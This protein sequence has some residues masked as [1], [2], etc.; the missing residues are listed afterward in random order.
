M[1]TYQENEHGEFSIGQATFSVGHPFHEK[2]LAEVA[3]GVAVAHPYKPSPL[4]DVDD[5]PL[6]MEDR[7]T[8]AEAKAGVTPA[9]HR[10]ARQAKRDRNEA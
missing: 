4:P 8:I 5:I 9:D 10:A 1:K 2:M 6:S 7:M 3:R